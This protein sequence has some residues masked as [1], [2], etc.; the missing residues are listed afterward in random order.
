M[1]LFRKK[2]VVIE[3]VLA[4]DL[5]DAFANNWAALPAWAEVAYDNGNIVA[6]TNKGFTIKTLEGDHLALPTDMD[7]KTPRFDYLVPGRHTRDAFRNGGGVKAE[8]TRRQPKVKY[9]TVTG[10]RRERRGLARRCQWPRLSWVE[11]P[12]PVEHMKHAI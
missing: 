6:I 9:W 4:A 12:P 8:K 3:A 11:T 5:I 2:P 1:G 7:R 10:D